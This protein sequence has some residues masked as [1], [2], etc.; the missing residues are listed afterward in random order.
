MRSFVLSQ[1][2]HDAVSILLACLDDAGVW[3]RVPGGLAGNVYGSRWPLHDIDVDVRKDE[4]TR[5]L[6]AVGDFLETPPRP[7]ADDEFQ[8]IL[9][10]ARIEGVGVDI[11]QLEDAFV[12]ED[13]AWTPLSPDP[14]RRTLLDWSDFSVWAIPLDDL[15]DYKTRLG[16]TADVEDL[17]HL[18]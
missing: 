17:R 14:S 16:R 4:W 7:Y 5:V 6:A 11:A 1:A 2:Q 8:L 15:I 13:G 10:N 3:Y 12:R 9:A 18:A